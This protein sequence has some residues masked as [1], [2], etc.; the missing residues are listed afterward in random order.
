MSFFNVILSIKSV[1]LKKQNIPYN[2]K[3]SLLVFKYTFFFFFHM[4]AKAFKN[5]KYYLYSW[6]SVKRIVCVFFF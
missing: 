3:L 6:R 5:I 1:S 4:Y 2:V